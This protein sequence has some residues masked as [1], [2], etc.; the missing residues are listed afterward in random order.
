MSAPARLPRAQRRDEI[1]RGAAR[2][3]VDR[4]YVATSMEE[5][6]SES[7]ITKLIV[8]RHFE[9]KA[10]LYRAVL[11]D[12]VDSIKDADLRGLEAGVG[13]SSHARALLC[14]ARA[15]PDGFRLLFRH[16]VR[17]PE[18]AEFTEA[19][20]RGGVEFARGLLSPVLAS[21]Y[22]LDWAAETALGFTV[23]ATLNWLDSGDPASDEEFV[24]LATRSL[25]ALV[26]T[27]IAHESKR[28]E[29]LE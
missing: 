7:G 15:N 13:P 5:I 24:A 4:G 12:V 9:S 18:F 2:A 20:R 22:L 6:A 14:A 23:Q 17:E 28:S 1:L 25:E 19:S 27:W 3:F 29:E 26:H 16:A 8:Y 10:D 11:T 21:G